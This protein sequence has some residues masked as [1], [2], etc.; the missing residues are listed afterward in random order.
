M[1][2][3]LSVQQLM[4]ARS[5][6]EHWLWAKERRRD[7]RQLTLNEMR[8]MDEA[9]EMTTHTITFGDFNL[10]VEL[11]RALDSHEIRLIYTRTWKE[12]L[13]KRPWRPWRKTNEVTMRTDGPPEV[14]SD[15]SSVKIR[16]PSDRDTVRWLK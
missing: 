13:F 7:V 11:S 16:L 9:T 3:N 6:Y 10:P 14:E 8:V 1:S 15:G 5:D 2:F 4:Q 12:R